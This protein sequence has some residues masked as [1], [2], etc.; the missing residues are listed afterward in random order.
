MDVAAGRSLGLADDLAGLGA[1]RRWPAFAAAAADRGVRGMFA[2]PMAA[3]AALIGVLD[4]YRLPGP[5]TAEDLAQG[6]VFAGPRCTR[7]PAWSPPS[8]EYP[9][10]MRWQHSAHTPMLAAGAWPT[11]PLTYRPA[12]LAADSRDSPHDFPG[13]DRPE[14]GGVR[15]DGNDSPEPGAQP[16]GR[17]GEET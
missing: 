11:L 15:D 4:V 13:P 6:L 12:R 9:R 14:V 17:G 2:F 8:S 3:G 1:Q 16:G 7:P 10:R 5:P